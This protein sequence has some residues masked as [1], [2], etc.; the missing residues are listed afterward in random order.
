MDFNLAIKISR[1][2][3]IISIDMISRTQ[4]FAR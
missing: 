2:F 4:F 1:S 3:E